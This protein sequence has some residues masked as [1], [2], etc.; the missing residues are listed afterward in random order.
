MAASRG[1]HSSLPPQDSAPD[2]DTLFARCRQGDSVASEK[3][4]ALMYSE[5][6]ALASGY[7]RG[8]PAGHTLQPTALVNEAYLKLSRRPPGEWQGRAHFMGMAARAM[9]SV[10]IDHARARAVRSH[11][12]IDEPSALDQI[13]ISYEG[14]SFDLIALDV[15]LTE[16]ALF[17]PMMAKAVE[18]RFFGG[19][20]VDEVAEVLRISKRT[21]ER[22]WQATRAWLYKEVS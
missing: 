16:L 8:Q 2:A 10:L 12:S 6:H 4:L 18:L 19:L 9:R 15:A 1:P 7:M 14:R 20:T 22:E 21:L 17:D 13:V 5:L 11:T 3:L